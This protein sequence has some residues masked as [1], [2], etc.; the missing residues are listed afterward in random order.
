LAGF[1]TADDDVE[2]AGLRAEH[3]GPMAAGR[4]HDDDRP[5]VLS[6]VVR[7]LEKPI[8]ERPKKAAG[9]ELQNGFHGVVGRGQ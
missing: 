1:V 9:A 4:L 2:T 3:F 7:M 5:D 8:D 6:A